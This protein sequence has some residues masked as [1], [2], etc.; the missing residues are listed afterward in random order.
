MKYWNKKKIERSSWSKVV[1]SSVDYNKERFL[2]CQRQPSTGRFY[3][4]YGNFS[5]WFE[6]KEDAVMFALRWA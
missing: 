3:R 2:W 5:W 6:H 4:Y 1:V